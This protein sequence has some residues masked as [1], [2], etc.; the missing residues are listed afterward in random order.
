M[1][2]DGVHGRELDSTVPQERMARKKR[3]FTRCRIAK[4]TYSY[5]L[6]VAEKFRRSE[7]GQRGSY[8]ACCAMWWTIDSELAARY[9]AK[10][11][12]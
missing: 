5:E 4:G 9:H 6:L 8:R 11:Q 2:R 10:L 7:R 12:S 1:R 3:A